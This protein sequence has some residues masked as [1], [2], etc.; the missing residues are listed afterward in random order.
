MVGWRMIVI[1]AFTAYPEA[2]GVFPTERSEA[3]VMGIIDGPSSKGSGGG[4][5]GG[6]RRDCEVSAV[7]SMMLLNNL[8]LYVGG[9][10]SSYLLCMYAVYTLP[11]PVLCLTGIT[12]AQLE[13]AQVLNRADSRHP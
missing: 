2:V 11:L 5:E 6:G 13:I 1:S 4:V 3:L 9:L 8:A 10:R 12:A 7:A